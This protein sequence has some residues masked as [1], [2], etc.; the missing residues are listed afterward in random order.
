MRQPTDQ[1]ILRPQSI[2]NLFDIAFRI[3]RS[4]IIMYIRTVAL[5]F[6]FLSPFMLLILSDHVTNP[7]EWT[8]QLLV[9][10]TIA[11]ASRNPVGVIFREIIFPDGVFI[12]TVAAVML[13]PITAHAYGILPKNQHDF[14]WL[15]H[16]RVWLLIVLIGLPVIMLRMIGMGFIAD[17]VRIPILLVPH[18]LILEQV[19]IIQALRRGWSL[20]WCNLL[21][22]TFMFI[23]TLGLVR[24]AMFTPFMILAALNQWLPD[25]S[26]INP[27]TFSRFVP[28]A[29][30]VAELLIYPV[31]HIALTL[32]YYDF[33]IRRDGLDMALAITHSAGNSTPLG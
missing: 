11:I 16:G 19:S 7:F 13:A 29:A 14:Q 32:L 4:K 30:L 28:F 33:R 26:F 12:W 20:V 8:F 9:L 25:S 17:I 24:L 10:G 22:V 2:L 21:R 18:V 1:P 31:A 5:L 15:K 3:Y 6:I 23:L 27:D